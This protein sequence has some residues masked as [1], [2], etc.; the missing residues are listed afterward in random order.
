VAWVHVLET[1]SDA[2]FNVQT[3]LDLSKEES[4]QVWGE[5]VTSGKAPGGEAAA[6]AD[7]DGDN[8]HC[9]TEVLDSVT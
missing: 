2:S 3:G 5:E 7:A 9:S 8:R 1:E 4:G 6:A